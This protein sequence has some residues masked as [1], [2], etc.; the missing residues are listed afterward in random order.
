MIIYAKARRMLLTPSR[1]LTRQLTVHFGIQM[2]M[3]Q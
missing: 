1:M 3:E 2:E